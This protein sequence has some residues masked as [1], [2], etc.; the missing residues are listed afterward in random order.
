M[1]QLP[2]DHNMWFQQ[3]GAMAHT[4]RAT[5]DLLRQHFPNRIISKNGDVRWPPF[6]PDLTVP[7]FFLLGYLKDKVYANNP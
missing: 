2:E 1:P 5:M 4:I 7:D 3:D 6:S